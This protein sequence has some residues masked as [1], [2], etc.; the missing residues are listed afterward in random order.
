MNSKKEVKE[1]FL[2]YS[3][4]TRT[5]KAIADSVLESLEQLDLDV[6]NIRGQGYDGASNMSSSRVGLQALKITISSLYSLHWAL[7]ESCY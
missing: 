4:L 1:E 3:Y 2:K 6:K 5:G 7:L